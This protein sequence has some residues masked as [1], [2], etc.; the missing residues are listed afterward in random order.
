MKILII[1]EANQNVASGHLLESIA[2]YSKAVQEKNIVKLAVNSNLREEWKTY[3]NNLD[4]VT[5]GN[6]LDNG[7]IIIREY[8]KR[9]SF[10][11]IVTDVRQLLESHVLQL[12]KNYSG[13]LICLDEWGNRKL[14]CDIII[15]NM[16]NE[17]FWNYNGSRAK[18]YCG[19]QY[20]ML[21]S[22]L[23]KYHDKDKKISKTINKILI[24]MGGVDIYNHTLRILQTIINNYRLK[25]IDVVLGGGYTYEQEI[26]SCFA[27]D[28][29]VK[30]HKN[31]DYM[32]EL[33]LEDDIAFTAGGNTLYEMAAVGIPCIVLPTMKHEE[34]NGMAFA[35]KGYGVV[36]KDGELNRL[37]ETIEFLNYETRVKMSE[38]G[39]KLI[40]GQGVD[41]VWNIVVKSK[42]YEYKK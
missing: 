29:R 9:E 32:F 8:L 13:L 15:N 40:D 2:L 5:Y 1:T 42:R 25:R 17:Y 33:F 12:R 10:D 14:S 38:T 34:L 7:I 6:D 23:K 20:L 16:M 3:I 18:I 41:R 30:I 22:S 21:K 24:S 37:E 26:V 39:K 31:I 35:E 27:N 4:T 11:V 28:K 19:P 36:I